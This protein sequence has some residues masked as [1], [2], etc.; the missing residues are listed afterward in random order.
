MY[1]GRYRYGPGYWRRGWG[2]HPQ[3]RGYWG[4]G[5]GPGWGWG[6]YWYGGEAP[7]YEPPPWVGPYSAGMVVPDAAEGEWLRAEAAA[8]RAEAEAI[9]NELAEIEKRIAEIEPPEEEA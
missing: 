2:G 8:L 4:G 6:R 5:S 1:R 3:A 9:K 7:C